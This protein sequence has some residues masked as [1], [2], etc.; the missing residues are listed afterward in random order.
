MSKW[1]LFRIPGGIAILLAMSWLFRLFILR[2]SGQYDVT[3]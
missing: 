2:M 1:L 3:H